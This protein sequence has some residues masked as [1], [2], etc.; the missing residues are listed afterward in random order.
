M[1]FSGHFSQKTESAP[2]RGIVI[3]TLSYLTSDT[4]LV[5]S[6]ELYG[7]IQRYLKI[8]DWYIWANMDKGQITLPVFQSL[9]AYWPGLQVFCT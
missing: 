2:W 6:I 3:C 4:L 1:P 7:K 8:N 5:S 9:D